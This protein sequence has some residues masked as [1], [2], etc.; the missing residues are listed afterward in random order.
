MAIGEN[1]KR[2]RES[3]GLTQSQLGDA[4]GVTDKAVSTWESGTRMPRMN[5]VDRLAAF[6]GIDKRDLLF[7]DDDHFYRL[8]GGGQGMENS[9]ERCRIAGWLE[10]AVRHA[11]EQEARKAL[12]ICWDEEGNMTSTYTDGIE[13]KENEGMD[14]KIISCEYHCPGFVDVRIEYTS[15]T[16]AEAREAFRAVKHALAQ[17]NARRK[18]DGRPAMA[19]RVKLVR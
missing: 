17:R 6:F 4:I 12:L 7:C 15:D 14:E 11:V 13:M 16:E 2:L 3:R 1:I 19:Y 8:R 9:L 18:Y 10:T 5:V